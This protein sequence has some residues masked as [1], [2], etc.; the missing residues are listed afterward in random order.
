M[1]SS[2]IHTK[3][4][5]YVGNAVSAAAITE[6]E[7]KSVLFRLILA[8]APSHLLCMMLVNS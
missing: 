2:N 3:N 7:K 5:I 1:I 4:V 8:V 6:N